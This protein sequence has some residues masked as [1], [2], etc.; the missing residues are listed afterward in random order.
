MWEGKQ[1]RM[2]IFLKFVNFYKYT[3]LMFENLLSKKQCKA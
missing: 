1:V 2:V 3:F